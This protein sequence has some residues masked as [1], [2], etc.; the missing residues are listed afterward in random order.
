M[1]NEPCYSAYNH[2]YQLRGWKFKTRT[3]RT[4]AAMNTAAAGI[5]ANGEHNPSVGW[6]LL[7]GYR[8]FQ[9]RGMERDWHLIR[10]YYPPAEELR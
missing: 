1:S 9:P 3:Y 10:T 6:P 7:Y 2:P 8:H 5:L 4:E